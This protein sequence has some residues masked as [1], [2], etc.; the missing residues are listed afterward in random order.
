MS[1]NK[2]EPMPTKG[3]QAVLPE[4]I[5]D[6]QAR[7]EVGIQKYGT[8]LETDNG[9]DALMDF[10]QEYLDGAMYFK[11]HLM[12]RDGTF[13]HFENKVRDW[14]NARGLI[15]GTT[16]LKQY[17]KLHEEYV[18][19]GDALIIPSIPLRH[20]KLEIGDILVVLANICTQLGCTL[21]ECAWLAYD[22]I[23]DRK[24]KMINGTFVKEEDLCRNLDQK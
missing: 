10:Y 23:K 13:R 5:Q 2:P 6:L 4:L 19:L 12:E 15:Y 20:T 14:A 3:K 18:E 8:P 17:E 21:E 9:R 22:K 7:A 1:A 24:G 11:Q 16:I